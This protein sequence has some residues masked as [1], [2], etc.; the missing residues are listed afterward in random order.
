[1]KLLRGPLTDEMFDSE[2][3]D[4]EHV[5]RFTTVLLMAD[6]VDDDEDDV[7]SDLVM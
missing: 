6:D 3:V 5:E 1:M 7:V 2:D 4:W